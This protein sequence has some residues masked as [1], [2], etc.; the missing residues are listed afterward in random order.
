MAVEAQKKM[1]YI[2]LKNSVPDRVIE[3]L[4]SLGP[5]ASCSSAELADVV[6][7]PNHA[8]AACLAAPRKHGALI[9]QK[10]ASG[11]MMWSIGDGVP[12]YPDDYDHSLEP[13]QVIVPASPVHVKNEAD[14]LS[15]DPAPVAKKPAPEKLLLDEPKKDL[16]AQIK[17]ERKP[18]RFGIFSDGTM[19]IEQND[20]RIELSA[21]DAMRLREFMATR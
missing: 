10:T 16:V 4:K 19:L 15:R 3:H 14:A 9:A 6:G 7:Q 18:A 20:R 2:P 17:A 1:N 11:V 8:I 5:G 13:K 21:G 12:V